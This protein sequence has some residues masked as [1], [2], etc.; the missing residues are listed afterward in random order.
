MKVLPSQRK[1]K[2]KLDFNFTHT[3]GLND[4]LFCEDKATLKQSIKDN[5]KKKQRTCEKKAL[6]YS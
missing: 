4:G 2:V 5:Q 1:K 6:N 3:T